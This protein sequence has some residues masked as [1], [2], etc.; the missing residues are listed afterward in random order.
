MSEDRE[1]V[2][3]SASDTGHL[4]ETDM[5]DSIQY[6]LEQFELGHWPET[7]DVRGYA[8]MRV[9]AHACNPLEHVLEH[10]DE[11]YGDPDGGWADPTDAMKQAEAEFLA[12]IEREYTPWACEQ[13]ATK[14]V[15]VMDWI[16]K[17][18][19]DWLGDDGVEA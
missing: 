8:R 11:E 15:N 16:K 10:L 1:I 13:V 7:V 5:D 9:G 2:F 12:V 18:R 3:W 6:H 19:P 17:N 14:T 4:T